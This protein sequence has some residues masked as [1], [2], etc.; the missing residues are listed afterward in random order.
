MGIA[1]LPF[2]AGEGIIL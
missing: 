1:E 2:L